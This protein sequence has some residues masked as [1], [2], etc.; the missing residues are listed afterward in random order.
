MVLIMACLDTLSQELTS[1]CKSWESLV[2]A[3][4]QAGLNMLL[5]YFAKT[6]QKLIIAKPRH[7]AW[8]CSLRRG[9][10]LGRWLCR[11]NTTSLHSLQIYQR[12][13]L[14][15]SAQPQSQEN[16]KPMQQSSSRTLT[17]NSCFEFWIFFYD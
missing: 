12:N 14:I 8:V 16:T 13:Q 5:K 7:K 1:D 11:M 17:Y 3:E 6:F 15:L 10:R 4:A 2:T 9:P